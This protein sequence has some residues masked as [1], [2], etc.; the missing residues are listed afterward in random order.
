MRV[1][2]AIALLAMLAVPANALADVHPLIDNRFAAQTGKFFASTRLTMRVD[3][4]VGVTPGSVFEFNQAFRDKDDDDTF[5]VEF[6][7]QFGELW[8][9]G[10]QHF[11][12]F[13]NDSASLQRDIEWE[14]VTYPAGI[15]VA[16]GNGLTVTRLYFGRDFVRD[17]KQVFSAGFGIHWLEIS[18]YIQGEGL[19]DDNSIG[20]A[21]EE[22]EASG[23]LPNVGAWYVYTPNDKWAFTARAGWLSA[24]VDPY[25]GEIINTSVGVHYTVAKHFGL[26]LHYNLF[27]LNVGVD[28]TGWR[29][30]VDFRYHGP[31][32]S[33]AAYWD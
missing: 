2:A 31:F 7:W 28:D 32:I 20:F 30:E 1:R 24:S 33:I 27:R 10:L 22:A 17:D 29:G 13:D 16:G 8:S 9:F 21:R 25:D 23:P 12:F 15:D 19:V 4:A 11:E 26:G 3:G 18:A 6:D 5:A 14:G